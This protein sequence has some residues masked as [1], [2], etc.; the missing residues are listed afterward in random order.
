MVS[1]KCIEV[2]R[3]PPPCDDNRRRMRWLMC[4]ARKKVEE[5]YSYSESMKMAW[6]EVRKLC[7]L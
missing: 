7:R 3:D 5:G 2:L 4:Y 6:R 1:D